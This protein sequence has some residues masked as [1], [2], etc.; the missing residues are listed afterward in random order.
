MTATAGIV[1]LGEMKEHLGGTLDLDDALLGRLMETARKHIEQ[2][3]GPLD[4]FEDDVPED[5]KGALKMLVGHLYE[6]REA[7]FIGQGQVTEVPLGFYDLIGSY[8]KW[9]F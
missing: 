6:N 8:R 3:C 9:A 7:S 4:D 2:W 1:P 5:L